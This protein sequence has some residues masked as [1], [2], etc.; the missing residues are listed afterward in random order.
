MRVL[1]CYGSKMAGTEGIAAAMAEELRNKAFDVTLEDAHNLRSIEGFDAVI[2]GGALYGNRWHA[3]A[4]RF[5]ASHLTALRKVPVWI[6]SSGPLDTS[7]ST[8]P[9]APVDEVRVLMQRMGAQGH[10]T[11][12]GRLPA[13][14]TGFP[15][16]AMARKRAGDWRDTDQI[17]AWTDVVAAALP[18]AR[19][20][21]ASDPPA[22]SV[23]RLI[24]YGVA[25]WAAGS[26]ATWLSAWAL[27]GNTAVALHTVAAPIVFCGV[28]LS[29]FRAAGAREP[30]PVAATFATIVV[31][32]DAAVAG[33]AILRDFWTFTS[34]VG[35]WLPYPLIFLATWAT[36]AILRMGPRPTR[37]AELPPRV[38][39]TGTHV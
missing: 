38:G 21:P 32:L 29:Y 13:D 23:R 34:T 11:F 18:S 25:G 16:A 36:G 10:M 24:T 20:R 33:G 39:E 14:A 26:V 30:V 1:V 6:F 9:I 15:A 37:A 19:P 22:R 8:H 12:G 7:A 17:R 35:T 28:S 5:V 31:L 3:D 2:V 27:G 4:H